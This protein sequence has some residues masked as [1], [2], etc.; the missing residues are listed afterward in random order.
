MKFLTPYR[1]L[2]IVFIVSN[3]FFPLQARGEEQESE[4]LPESEMQPMQTSVVD[5]QPAEPMP[6]EFDWIMLVS[7]EWLKGDLR[8]LYNDEV[9]FDSDELD[10]LTFDWDDVL[11]IKT[12]QAKEVLLNDRTIV[13]GIV[14]VKDGVIEVTQGSAKVQRSREE[15]V[16]IADRE[17]KFFK[18]WDGNISLSADIKEG[19]VSQNDFVFKFNTDRR[20]AKTRFLVD[21]V[22]RYGTLEDETTENNQ[23]FTTSMD[24]FVS[25][26]WFLRPIQIE[27]FSD[28][29]QSIDIRFTYTSAIGYTIIDRSKIFWE[30]HIGPGYQMT[31]YDKD[32]LAEGVDEKQETGVG[33]LGTSIDWDI[34]GD[35]E[36]DAKW[37]LQVVSEESGKYNQ[38]AEVTLSIDFLGDFDLDITYM[39]DR[40]A[41]PVVGP[42]EQPQKQ[43][44][45]LMVGVGYEF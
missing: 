22:S 14:L 24:W 16:S 18:Q 11:T 20:T 23:R 12:Y 36:L 39:V 44:T 33:S 34:T 7:G 9:E 43:D 29:F 21:F 13:Y 27:L 15:V 38:H 1:Y 40:V 42:D 37:D 35:I 10:L 26:R 17:K 45:R 41:E 32:N 2:M 8:A 28:Y 30:A 4:E 31:R 19:N 3:V 25:Q 6:K 5:W